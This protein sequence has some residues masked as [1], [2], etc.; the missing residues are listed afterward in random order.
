MVGRS[1]LRLP[2]RFPVAVVAGIGLSLSLAVSA[3]ACS[4]PDAASIATAF[5]LTANDV[6]QTAPSGAT[7]QNAPTT[8]PASLLA[9]IGWV[10]SGWRQFSAS[11]R[12]LVS[13]DFGY[14]IMQ[15]TSGMSG[16]FGQVRGGIDP[17]TQSRI[18]SEYRFNIAYGAGILIRKWSRTPRI[19]DGDPAVLEN[20]YYAVW[21]Y[22]GWGWVNNPN[23]PR[24]S[25]RGTPAS[26]PSGFPYQERVLYLV[27]H[28][29]HDADGNPLWTPI[30]VALPSPHTIGATPASFTP[31]QQHR[32]PPPALA[33]VYHTGALPVLAPSRL[34]TV[35]VRV[36]NTG[37][38]EW[39]ASGSDAVSLVYH[40]FTPAGD[41]WQPFSPFSNGVVAL[42]QRPVPLPHDV[43]P[44]QT[45]VVSA[46]VQSPSVTG[47]YRLVWD[48]QQSGGTWFS[49]LGVEPDARTIRVQTAP[50]TPTPV[51]VTTTPAPAEDMAYVAD[52]SI[53][54][55]T[56]VA[57][58][59]SF[60]KG[61]L[62]FNT[63]KHGWSSGWVLTRV[64]GK[65]LGAARMPVP[66]TRPCYSANIVASMRAPAKP[67]RYTA[68]W[69]MRDPK[70]HL[71]GERLTVVIQV[72]KGSPGPQP[73][74]SPGPT[75]GSTRTPRPTPTPTPSG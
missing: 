72:Q 47:T 10:E 16:A 50:S 38:Q 52:T 9:A 22:N 17:A 6:T 2:I 66:A 34:R 5:D 46:T 19:G 30:P 43:L 7:A 67:G 37:T 3:V 44:G 18:A 64:G 33:A 70:G 51:P 25:R 21:A 49:Q 75:P 68:T 73:T 20:W 32:Q 12:P 4:Q 11:H 57:P 39:L 56:G 8:V 27:A 45:V 1:L 28:P 24:F 71:V 53:P 62:V 65:P 48:L 15:V 55:G 36:T 35:R 42:G 61:W 14:G 31:G 60:T 69:R 40:L 58:R 41:P 74:P 26:N 54:D 59:A 63:G 13:P 23:N 29:P